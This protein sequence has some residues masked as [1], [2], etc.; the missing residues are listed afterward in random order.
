MSWLAELLELFPHMQNGV[1]LLDAM[2]N[3]PDFGGGIP[4]DDL[5]S[6]VRR[7]DT[8]NPNSME[9]SE[10]DTNASWGHSQFTAGS[11]TLSS[12]LTSWKDVGNC[13]VACQLIAAAIKTCK[14]ARHL[15]YKRNIVVGAYLSDI[16]LEQ[17]LDALWNI[18]KDAGGVSDIHYCFFYYN[19]QLSL[20]TNISLLQPVVKGKQKELVLETVPQLLH[21]RT[22]PPQMDGTSPQPRDLNAYAVPMES[23]LCPPAPTG[24]DLCPPAPMESDSRLPA[25]TE[26]NSC[27]PVL[28]E[29]DPC[30]PAPM[31]SN[32]S[33][34]APT[35][36]N[37]SSSVPTESNLSLRA[38]TESNP[39][40]CVPIDSPPVPQTVAVSKNLEVS[41][42]KQT[43]ANDN[44]IPSIA[45]A[46]KELEK[47]LQVSISF[48]QLL[49]FTP[50]KF[51]TH[52]VVERRCQGRT[53]DLGQTEQGIS[54]QQC[55]Q[56]AQQTRYV[57]RYIF[58]I[59]LTGFHRIY[60][61]HSG[62]FED[63]R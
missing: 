57:N 4:S 13:A 20:T 25:P 45:V 9:F 6:F 22:S 58:S 54:K 63:L 8:A 5:T 19:I 15:C 16:Y 3:N 35:E 34:P 50:A 42:S 36:S 55:W 32:P 59:R 1:H 29:S 62:G 48:L 43:C 18:W 27:P 47:L 12:V 60:L 2:A 38:P 30:P 24:S 51:F 11:L 17:V 21:E 10:D 31:E 52:F 37:P 23:D 40:P 39:S 53:K 44:S 7:I 56:A 46:Q 26:S 33:P 28:M 61:C 14:V 41:P 49:K